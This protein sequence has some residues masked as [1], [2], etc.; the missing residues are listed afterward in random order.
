[1]K[2]KIPSKKI[3]EEFVL[4]CELKGCQKAV[5]FLAE[6]YRVRRMRVILDGKRVGNGDVACYFENKAYFTKKGLNKRNALHEF[7]HHLVDANGLKMPL[8]S[9]E[10]GANE[11]ARK[12]L[13]RCLGNC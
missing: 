5:D 1:M 9:E 7:Y 10:R 12:C 4:T 2:V 6:Y 8:R 11:Y 3:R 13:N